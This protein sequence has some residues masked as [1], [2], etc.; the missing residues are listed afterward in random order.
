MLADCSRLQNS[1]ELT[2]RRRLGKKKTS[3]A[4]GMVEEKEI[5]ML[6]SNYPALFTN[7][8]SVPFDIQFQRLFERFPLL[9]SL[10]RNYFANKQACPGTSVQ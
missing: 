7:D 8:F 4:F 2:P 6:Q 3:R 9:F 10:K 5:P 1:R